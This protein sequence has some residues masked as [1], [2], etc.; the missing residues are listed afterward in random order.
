VAVAVNDS[1]LVEELLIRAA[2]LAGLVFA[3]VVVSRAGHPESLAK[4]SD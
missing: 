3:D 1:D 2:S 4:F